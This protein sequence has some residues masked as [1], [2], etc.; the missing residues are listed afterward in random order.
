[1]PAV[2]GFATESARM[3]FVGH[4]RSWNENSIRYLGGLGYG[5]INMTF[6]RPLFNVLAP[7]APN[8]GIELG[9]KGMKNSKTTI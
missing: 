9:L 3:A 4:K 8:E 2:G 1:M 5:D 7:L 6:Y